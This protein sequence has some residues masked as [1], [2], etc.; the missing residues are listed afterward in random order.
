MFCKINLDFT[1]CE[2]SIAVKDKFLRYI[3]DAEKRV[4]AGGTNRNAHQVYNET[5]RAGMV[6]MLAAAFLAANLKADARVER[7]A[8][9]REVMNMVDMMS[10]INALF[11][12]K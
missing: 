8:A 6:K 4:R 2:D 5:M 7:T 11:V 9:R 3:K 10:E 1:K 12:K